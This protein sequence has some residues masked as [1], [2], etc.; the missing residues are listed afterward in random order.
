VESTGIIGAFPVVQFPRNC[1]VKQRSA[2]LPEATCDWCACSRVFS[3]IFSFCGLSVGQVNSAQPSNRISLSA[4]PIQFEPNRAQVEDS[5]HFV[6]HMPNF[7]LRLRGGEFALLTENN[8]GPR[9]TD[10]VVQFANANQN[11]RI[12]GSDMKPSQSNYLLGRDSSQWHVHIPNFG[13]VT[14]SN[15]YPG[16][17]LA[18]YGNGQRLEHDFLVS[19]GAN[20]RSIRLRLLGSQTIRLDADGRLRIVCLRV[21][22]FCEAEGV[23]DSRK[24]EARSRGE[25]SCY[26]WERDRFQ[27]RPLRPFQAFGYR[28]R[29]DLFDFSGGH[30]DHRHRDC[31]RFIGE[32]VPNWRHRHQHFSGDSGGVSTDLRLLCDKQRRVR[33]KIHTRWLRLGVL[34]LPR[35]K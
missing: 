4:L 14:Y 11:A 3:H 6:A 26:G 20:Y 24:R 21:I 7:D 35:R 5:A 22:Y 8:K 17:D 19:P 25:I 28:S 32:C 30:L 15:L 1:A 13:R 23:S 27:H 29:I 34:N 12:D 9:S 31:H 33:N 10:F 18:F 16:I 2:V